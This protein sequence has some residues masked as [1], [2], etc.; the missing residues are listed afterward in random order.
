[1]TGAMLGGMVAGPLG[2]AVGAVGGAL[3]AAL[4]GGE[5]QQGNGLKETVAAYAKPENTAAASSYAEKGS[6]SFTTGGDRP[7]TL[8]TDAKGNVSIANSSGDS[9][10]TNIPAAAMRSYA[11]TTEGAKTL[12]AVM[13][14]YTGNDPA[15]LA[16]TLSGGF[17]KNGGDEALKSFNDALQK[18]AESV[19]KLSENASSIAEIRNGAKGVELNG[20]NGSVIP[21]STEADRTFSFN[22]Q[23]TGIGYQAF[24]NAS[25]ATM[26]L[27]GAAT[28]QLTPQQLE[29][30]NFSALTDPRQLA[31]ASAVIAAAPDF[32][33]QYAGSPNSLVGM[34]ND[35]RVQKLQ[36]TLLAGGDKASDMNVRSNTE[37]YAAEQAEFLAIIAK[38]LSGQ[39]QYGLGGWAKGRIPVEPASSVSA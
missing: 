22:G 34:V 23:K 7:M 8:G 9:A 35:H 6:A 28:N 39:G 12:S 21:L 4:T 1:M 37:G 36:E 13:S 33:S 3:V 15:A 27:L 32:A 20:A 16:A 31:L 18:G 17:T 29:Q 11:S 10:S 30:Y 26:G 2:A 19:R 24:D 38:G 5:G 14:S 25:Q